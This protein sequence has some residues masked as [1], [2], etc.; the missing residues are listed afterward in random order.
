MSGHTEQGAWSGTTHSP[1]HRLSNGW[2]NSSGLW[3]LLEWQNIIAHWSPLFLIWFNRTSSAATQQSL[4]WEK[5]WRRCSLRCWWKFLLTKYLYIYNYD[6]TGQQTETFS[7]LHKLVLDLFCVGQRKP[8][9]AL[10]AEVKKTLEASKVVSNYKGCWQCLMERLSLLLWCKY[11][12]V[13]VP[14]SEQ[15]LEHTRYQSLLKSQ[16]SA[17]E[18]CHQVHVFLCKSIQMFISCWIYCFVIY[19]NIQETLSQH[20]ELAVKISKINKGLI[21][22]SSK[23]YFAKYL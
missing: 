18:L 21:S 19:L 6:A 11:L 1:E 15:A 22:S 9:E 17:L 20:K 13:P 16:S 2:A 8:L 10:V 4:G 5:N 12:N 14:V 7:E 23:I 3:Y